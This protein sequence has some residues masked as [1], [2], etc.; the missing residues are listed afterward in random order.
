MKRKAFWA[1]LAAGMTVVSTGPVRA[2]SE[3][4]SLAGI[5]KETVTFD[6]S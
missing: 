1:L 5:W 2:Q 3:K 4:I 6:G